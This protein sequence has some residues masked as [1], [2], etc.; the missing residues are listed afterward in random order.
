[1]SN[2]DLA[3]KA[4]Q[5]FKSVNMAFKNVSASECVSAVKSVEVESSSNVAKMASSSST[6][7]RTASARELQRVSL[8][9]FNREHSR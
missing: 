2:V 3:E 6:S 9:H 1:L 7:A 4:F 8:L 5:N